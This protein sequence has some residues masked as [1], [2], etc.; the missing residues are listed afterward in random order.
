MET[1]K[2]K[3]LIIL[4]FAG[5]LSIQT[6]FFGRKERLEQALKQSG[7]VL[8][9]FHDPARFWEDLVYPTWEEGGLTSEGYA[10]VLAKRIEE[11]LGKGCLPTKGRT[12][13]SY[14]RRTGKPAFLLFTTERFVQLYYQHSWIDPGWKSLFQ[15]FPSRDAISSRTP[16]D[17]LLIA[18]DHYAECTPFLR[19]LLRQ[20]NIKSEPIGEQTYSWGYP[21]PNVFIA[22]SADLGAWKK[23]PAFWEQVNRKLPFAA[24]HRILLIDD[25]GYNEHRGDPYGDRK[26]VEQRRDSILH[27][28]NSYSSTKVE[29]FPFLLKSP[30]TETPLVVLYQEYQALLNRALLFLGEMK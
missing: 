21:K 5:T 18:T 1:V 23:D 24:F 12:K 2:R 22:N 16:Q 15:N 3:R 7:L 11:L 19:R 30:V 29:V 8:W 20:W 10:R 6:V 14:V 27:C 17:T 28:L 26:R 9:G 25:F 4:D 13:K